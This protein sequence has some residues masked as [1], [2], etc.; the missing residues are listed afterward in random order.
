MPFIEN[1]D[2]FQK[3]RYDVSEMYI[4][5][6]DGSKTELPPYRVQSISIT[7]LYETNLFPIFRVELML[8]SYTY[9]KIIKNKDRVK[10]KIRIQKFYT[11]IDSSEKSLYRDYINDTYDLI[12]DNDDYNADEHLIKERNKLDYENISN[13]KEE[14]DINEVTSKIEFF[15]YKSELIDKMNT[16]VNNIISNATVNDGIQYIA[17]RIGLNNILMSN[18]HNTTNY[19]ELVIPPLKAKQAIKF[20]DTYYGL[21]KTG[22]MFYIDFVGNITY[23]LEYNS[24]CTAYQRNEN[25]ETDILIP[26]KS[27]NY[28]SHI[29]SLYR[30]GNTEKHFIIADNAHIAIRNET[31][32]QNA[33]ASTDA[34]IIDTYSGDIQTSS[35][36]AKVKDTKSIQIIKNNTENNMFSTMYDSIIN[37]KNVVIDILLADYDISALTPNKAFK[38]VFEDT[39]LSIKYRKNLLLS[40]AEHNLTRD[41]DS[42]KLTSMIKIKQL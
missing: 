13:R 11:D 27:N 34:K 5:Y 42:F 3:W 10:F 31:I 40:Q 36:T 4:L 21:Y 18:P 9:Y 24:K 12:L 23:L 32:S 28:A 16:I 29:C 35:S 7:H 41:G 2:K 14:N 39:S 6:P 22:M 8:S 15:L 37:T 38:S 33:Y 1:T 30:R 20:L 26:L 25:K 17:T 19:K